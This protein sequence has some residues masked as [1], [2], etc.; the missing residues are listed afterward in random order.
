MQQKLQLTVYLF[1]LLYYLFS[2][3]KQENR[4]GKCKRKTTTQKGKI[5]CKNNNGKQTQ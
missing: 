1:T 5:N 3:A 2:F 4:N